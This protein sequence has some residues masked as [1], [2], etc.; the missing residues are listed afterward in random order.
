MTPPHGPQL[1][2]L[3]RHCRQE[4]FGEPEGQGAKLKSQVDKWSGGIAVAIKVGGWSLA[5]LAI[6]V[7]LAMIVIPILVDAKIQAAFDRRFGPMPAQTSS[8]ALAQGKANQ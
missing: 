8:Q 1:D 2:D 3:A 6:L 5:F 4:C 7:P